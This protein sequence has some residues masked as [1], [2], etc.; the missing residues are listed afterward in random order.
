MN[1]QSVFQP[2]YTRH[3]SGCVI[4]ANTSNP[5]SLEQA[6]RWKEFFDKKT[7][8]PNE[9]SIPATL[10]INHDHFEQFIVPKDEKASQEAVGIDRDDGKNDDVISPARARDSDN[11]EN[12]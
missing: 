8:V 11:E 5:R 1:A 2:L 10:F 12:M 9:P 7:K 4:V 6:H 3:C